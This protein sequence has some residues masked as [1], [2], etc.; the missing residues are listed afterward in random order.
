MAVLSGSEERL[1]RTAANM[2]LP[3][4]GLVVPRPGRVNSYR[5]GDVKGGKAGHGFY[6]NP[7][8]GSYVS[9]RK[10]PARR[11]HRLGERG[12]KARSHYSASAL[13]PERE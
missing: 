11:V 7:F 13:N 8:R 3:I 12:V 1:A 4:S 2:S 6:A 10:R 5:G 9:R